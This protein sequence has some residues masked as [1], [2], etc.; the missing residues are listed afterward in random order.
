[1]AELETIATAV[2]AVRVPRDEVGTLESGVATRL[3]RIEPVQ[4]IESLDVTGVNPRMNDV[5][6]E[7]NVRVSLAVDRPDPGAVRRAF[8][9]EVGVEV[10][11]VVLDR[12]RSVDE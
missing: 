8:E 12:P 10:D 1:M 9:R 3:D 7:V 4:S 2:L 11:R 6:T 5:R